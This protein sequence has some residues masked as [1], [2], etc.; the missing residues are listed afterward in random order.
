ML[1]RFRIV[2]EVQKRE[3]QRLGKGPYLFCMVVVPVFCVFFF[4]NIMSVGLPQGLPVAVVDQDNTIYSR[5][6]IRNLGVQQQSDVK[7]RTTSFDEARIAMQKGQIYGIYYIPD[8]FAANVIKGARPEISYYFNACYLMA[9]SLTFRDM[10]MM[11]ELANGKVILSFAEAR[12]VPTEDAMAR[13]QP[14]KVSSYVLGNRWLNYS[15]Y[16]NNTILPGILQL[17]IF[18]VTAYAIGMEIKLKTAREWLR[19]SKGSISLALL[20]KLS[21]HFMIFFV[22]GLFMLA[23]LYGYNSFPMGNGWGPMIA[24]LMLLIVASQA[25]GIFFIS[26]LP[27]PRLGL[28]FATLLG[29]LS[30]SIVGFTYPLTAMPPAIQALS[31]IFPLRH[32]FLIYVDQALNARAVYYSLFS[33]AFLVSFCLLP[34]LTMRRLKRAL[35]E[36]KYMP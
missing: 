9:G 15:I 32:Y 26:V 22:V 16:L 25:M 4:L 23:S 1:K 24:N 2:W 35:I 30:F 27:T 31:Y 8:G 34:M 17:M 6:L 14:I 3:L 29:M 33:Y 19:R 13:I 21:V 36:F 12:G 28:S 18:M 5:A 20:G 11:S 7:M 10:K